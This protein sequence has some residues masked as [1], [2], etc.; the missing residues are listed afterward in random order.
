MRRTFAVLLGGLLLASSGTMVL[1]QSNQ[2]PSIPKGTLQQQT[3]VTRSWHSQRHLS[4]AGLAKMTTGSSTTIYSQDFEDTT[5]GDVMTSGWQE[6]APT[7]GPMSAHAGVNCAA[8]NLSG[9]YSNGALDTLYLPPIDLP[10][11]AP[12]STL[13]L[14]FWEW[15]QLETGYDNGYVILSTDGGGSWIPLDSR[16]GSSPGWTKKDL[17]LT[18]YVGKNVRIAFVLT[19]D[20]SVVMSGWYVDDIVVWSE[21]PVPTLATK[22]QSLNSSSFPFIYMNVS[23][24]SSGTNLTNLT[25]A[26][27]D[28]YENETQQT[29]YFQVTAPTSSGGSRAADVVFV[30]DVTGSMGGMIDAVKNNMQSFI[31]ALNAGGV[32][33]RMGFVTFGDIVHTYNSGNLYSDTTQI[34]SVAQ[35]ITLGE[36]GIGSGGDTP[37]DQ[38]EA[39]YDASTMNFRP[40]AQRISI[41]ITN[42]NAHTLGDGSGV[43]NWTV[44]SLIT[45]LKLSGFTVY[46]VFETGDN[47]ELDQYLPIANTLNRDSSYYYVGDNFNDIIG[48]IGNTVTG[49]YVVRYYSS[50][51]LFDGALRRVRVR[52]TYAGMISDDTASY[53]PG[54]APRITRTP[55]TVALSAS[56]AE[57][58]ILTIA[59]TVVDSVVPLVQYVRLYYK[60]TSSTT[61]NAIDMTNTGGDV[62]AVDIPIDSVIAPGVDYYLLASDG[63]SVSTDPMSDPGENPYQIAVLPN[64]APV[65]THTPPTSLIPGTPIAIS[66]TI[67]DNT[68]LVAL[69]KLFYRQVGELLYSSVMMTSASGNVF[70]AVI[71]D[72]AVTAAGVEYYILAKDDFGIATT[73]GSPDHPHQIMVPRVTGTTI[74]SVSI[75]ASANGITDGNLY[76]GVDSGATDGFD[77]TYDFPK[78]PKPPSSYVY[79]SFPHPEWSG[80]LG[81][82]YLSDIRRNSPLASTYTSWIITVATDQLNANMAVSF[83]LGSTLPPEY[84]V[85]LKDVKT[86]L[87]QDLR[88]CNRFVY[89]TGSDGVRMLQLI[90]GTMTF[91]QSYPSGWSMT[92]LPV[93]TACALKDSI[94]GSTASSFLF[95][96][97]PSCGY[98]TA[99]AFTYGKGYWLGLVSPV[100]I[101]VQGAPLI[102]TVSLPLDKGF[103]MVASPFL[104]SAY[105]R[106]NVLIQ[107]EGMTVGLDSAVSLGW[108]SPAFYHYQAGAVSSY[109]DADTLIPWDAYWFAAIDS[110]L[111]IAFPSRL[112]QLPMVLGGGVPPAT[113]PAS[114]ASVVGL[115]W[116]L[117]LSLRAGSVVDQ[118]GAIG[119]M[120]DAQ[121]GF[122]A[123]YDLPHPPNP[124]SSEYAYLGFVHPDW[125][126]A[127]G[128]LFS[129]DMRPP[130]GD[131]TWTMVVGS[132]HASVTAVISW[133]SCSIPSTVDLRLRDLANGGRT[134]DMRTTGSYTFT[135]NGTDSLQISSLVTNVPFAVPSTPRD[136]TL[137]QNFPNPFNPATTIRFGLPY[138]SN[139]RLTIYNVL[140]QIVSELLNANVDAGHHERMWNADVASGMYFYRIEAV[141]TDD[142][143]KRF[144][145][146]RKM[147]LLK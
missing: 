80:P 20:V 62:Y 63:V 34:M 145:E 106:S 84:S 75:V 87:M 60:T 26:N 113:I 40:G 48:K 47:S 1:A 46:P 140:G 117:H 91:S 33:Y 101:A 90:I 10:S 21:V 105:S 41:L 54:T 86:G 121:N 92:G 11:L 120:S 88:A 25:A 107:R 8:T 72:G 115:D 96:Y 31:S 109:F 18:T 53:R 98:D 78:P 49:T 103:N 147:I 102:D 5:R 44:D 22:I 36:Y 81:P 42:S 123:R 15:Y 137:E 66:A 39:L 99:G 119:M 2:N 51:P 142:P 126:P 71:P 133:D 125:I 93:K 116:T 127:V 59:A 43:T 38:L 108:V 37:E 23:V 97:A 146:V 3:P 16:T 95:R 45:T 138:R 50:D 24:D 52:A 100:T 79:V 77:S 55:A 134:I 132:S 112:S 94:F 73:D 30:V 27:F 17:S 28:A 104:D 136:F 12:G 32:D 128:S 69:A 14:S 35:S 141:S 82:D 111:R 68:N 61:F 139:V 124:P 85:V 6:G 9:D 76:A 7:S 135:L 83:F 130:T 67:I 4:F 70:S 89:A 29:S 144:V 131:G 143:G 110:S 64:E 65:I 74:W 13:W 118:L 56:V 58:T 57:H 19:T 114:V 122:D 129:R